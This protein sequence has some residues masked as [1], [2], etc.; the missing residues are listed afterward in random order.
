MVYEIFS[1]GG[2]ASYPIKRGTYT[3]KFSYG[4]LWF[5]T[6][7]KFGD[8]GE[9]YV[10]LNNNSD[11]ID[12]QSNF[13]MNIGGYYKFLTTVYGSPEVSKKSISRSS[14]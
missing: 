3:I 12:I 1:S 9:Y 6:K 14:F 10:A 13:S 11:K 7:D 4:S 5:G 2:S 8:Q